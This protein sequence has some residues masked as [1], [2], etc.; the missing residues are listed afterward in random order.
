MI[1]LDLICFIM[2]AIFS[3]EIVKARALV[4]IMLRFSRKS[5]NCSVSR[6]VIVSIELFLTGEVESFNLFVEGFK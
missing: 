6:F 1:Y 5:W 4:C 3:Q 2:I